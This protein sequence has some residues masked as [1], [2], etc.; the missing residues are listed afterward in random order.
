MG[1]GFNR[2]PAAFAIAMREFRARARSY[3]IPRR[4]RILGLARYASH[5]IYL[6]HRR[7][8][9]VLCF[10]PCRSLCLL[11]CLSVSRISQKLVDR[12]EQKLVDRLGVSQWR[13]DSILAKISKV[14]FYNW[15]IGP[16]MIQGVL[17]IQYVH[18]VIL[19]SWTYNETMNSGEIFPIKI[20]LIRKIHSNT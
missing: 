4:N 13:I 19:K 10:Y 7:W 20:Y 18:D 14:I 9:E 17:A 6:H 16:K 1:M 2:I 5:Y 11:V 8:T 15:E 12:F 3:I